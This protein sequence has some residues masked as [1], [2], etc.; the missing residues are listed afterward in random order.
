MKTGQRVIIEQRDSLLEE[1][2]LDVANGQVGHAAR[3]ASGGALHVFATPRAN[4]LVERI[5]LRNKGAMGLWNSHRALVLPT[6][7][8]CRIRFGDWHL[9]IGALGPKHV[10]VIRR[11]AA[12]HQTI[13]LLSRTQV[14]PSVH[15]LVFQTPTPFDYL[16][17][18]WV[19][20][21]L[22]DG[23]TRDYS[24]ASAPSAQMDRFELLVTHVEGG[25]GSRILC[26]LDPGARIEM[27]GPNG[28]F[29][30]EERHAHLPAVFI[31]TGTGLAPLRAMIQEGA[32]APSPMRL[33]FGCRT[34]SEILCGGEF[35]NLSQSS[36]FQHRVTLSRPDAAWAGHRGYVQTHLHDITAGLEGAH[37]YICGLRKM[38]DAVRT[39]LKEQL[40]VD[41]GRIHS[42]RYDD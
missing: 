19:K 1:R 3:A 13:T 9:S 4:A 31:A 38:V 12:T 16:A 35:S 2:G 30:R 29:V 20:L 6:L 23:L 24:I 32:R 18:Q 11:I 40:G 39:T 27:L 17:G 26:A 25:E 42:E 34:E 14:T 5:C 22:R 41:R 36:D 28:L 37:F 15:H 10:L 7:S 8:G 33:L 21:T